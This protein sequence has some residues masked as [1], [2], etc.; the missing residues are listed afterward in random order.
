[1]YNEHVKGDNKHTL[2]T[3]YNIKESKT[4][5]TLWNVQ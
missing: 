1:M 4:Q 2:L 5:I 3:L